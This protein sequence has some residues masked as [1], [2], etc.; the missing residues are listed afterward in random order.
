MSGDDELE[1]LL[2]EVDASLSGTP[3]TA[4]VPA[5]AS[6]E[7]AASG[8]APGRWGRSLRTGLVAGVVCGAV[9]GTGTFLLGLLPLVDNPFSSAAGAFIGAFLTG[10]ALTAVR[11]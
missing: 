6:Q 11:R 10:A 3:A 9:V 5:A 4:P 7:V 8:A 1:R 2:R